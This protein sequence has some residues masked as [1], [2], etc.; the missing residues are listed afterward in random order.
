MAGTDEDPD[1]AGA[2]TRGEDD[3]VR[4]A[5]LDRINSKLERL[6]A[7]RRALRKA[8]GLFGENFDARVWAE[9]FASPDPDEINR[10]FAV[11]GGYLALLNTLSRRSGW[12][13]SWWVSSRR[14]ACWEPQ[15]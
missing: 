8:M 9:S 2:G 14:R 12:A 11:T 5:E 1:A 7:Q 15:G 4:T 10:V 6:S 3:D 13:P